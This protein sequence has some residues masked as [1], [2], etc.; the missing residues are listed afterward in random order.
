MIKRRYIIALTIGTGIGV[1]FVA[2]VAVLGYRLFG[3]WNTWQI[4][5]WDNSSNFTPGPELDL[6]HKAVLLRIC[7]VFLDDG[8]W[9]L[10]IPNILTCAYAKFDEISAAS[11]VG[12]CLSKSILITITMVSIVSF[13]AGMLSGQSDRFVPSNLEAQFLYGWNASIFVN[14]IAWGSLIAP[15]LGVIVFIRL[16]THTEAGLPD[17]TLWKSV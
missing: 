2:T 5:G 3:E 14:C 12:W 6:K 1:L 11:R 7:K 15:L 10:A 9:C 17:S 8:F 16:M 4:P 13:V